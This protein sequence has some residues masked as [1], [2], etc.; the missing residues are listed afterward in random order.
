MGRPKKNPILDEQIEKAEEKV[1]KY[2]KPYD[3]ALE[4][5]MALNM[6]KKEYREKKLLE[7]FYASKRSY[8]EVMEYLQRDPEDDDDHLY[9]FRLADPRDF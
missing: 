1:L 6:Q 3:A 4:K 2:K 9:D 5:L 8:E 7:A